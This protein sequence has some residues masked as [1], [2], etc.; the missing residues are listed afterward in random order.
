MDIAPNRSTEYF[1]YYLFTHGWTCSLQG[2]IPGLFG[3]SHGA[4]QFMAYEE[5]KKM[6]NGFRE[7]PV[8]TKFVSIF[9]VTLLIVS[10]VKSS[11]M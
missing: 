5:L 7:R 2:F 4:L 11:L 10:G 9:A 8:N 3:V 1:Y 6:Y